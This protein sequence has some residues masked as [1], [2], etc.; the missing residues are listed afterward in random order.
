MQVNSRGNSPIALHILLIQHKTLDS[1]ADFFP[2]NWRLNLS[3][4]DKNEKKKENQ[5]F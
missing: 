1:P 3:V 4:K 2:P 5:F